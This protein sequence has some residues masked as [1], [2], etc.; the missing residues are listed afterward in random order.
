MSNFFKEINKKTFQ[1][2]FESK[3]N[4]TNFF[5]YIEKN[6]QKW[7]MI[8][9]EYDKNEKT[10]YGKPPGISVTFWDK[11]PVKLSSVGLKNI[12]ISEGDEIN[13]YLINVNTNE[14]FGNSKTKTFADFFSKEINKKFSKLKSQND[15]NN[16]AEYI[17]KTK[18]N[19]SKLTAEEKIENLKKK[20]P[21]KILWWISGVIVVVILI[22]VG[23]NNNNSSQL[24]SPMDKTTFEVA[25]CLGFLTEKNRVEGGLKNGETQFIQMHKKFLS[26]IE[27]VMNKIKNESWANNHRIEDIKNLM[28]NYNNTDKELYYGLAVGQNMYKKLTKIQRGITT[29]A[30]SIVN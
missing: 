11:F 23:S 1:I 29:L 22:V 2:K 9:I 30:C 15:I 25:Q 8:D 12:I 5:K 17:E 13:S 4:Q 21:T 28:S 27:V 16:T 10:I 6:F 26:R 20:K 19:K 18:K 14:M 3:I 7:G 24:V